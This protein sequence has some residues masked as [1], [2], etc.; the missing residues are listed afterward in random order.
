MAKILI[1]PTGTHRHSRTDSLKVRL[2][3]YA[4]KTEKAYKPN[5]V[6]V[7]VIPDGVT[8]EQLNDKVWVATLP[9]IWQLNPHLCLFVQVGADITKE[10]LLEWIGDVLTADVLATIDDSI[11]QPN[12]AHLIS[13]FMRDKCKQATSKVTRFDEHDKLALNEF[14]S[15]VAV[16]TVSGKAQIIEPQSI[17]VGAA[18][19]DRASSTDLS[20]YTLVGKENP[21]NA[22]GTIDTVEIWMDYAGTVEAATFEE[23]SANTLT[24][25]D[26]ESL[27]LLTAGSKQTISSLT[28]DIV[29]GDYI[30]CNG[31]GNIERDNSG[32]GYWWYVGDA[33]PCTSQAFTSSILRTISIYGTGTESGGGLSIPI[34]MHHYT[35]NI[36]S[37]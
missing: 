4:D 16:E 26:T 10:L 27:G 22:T 17:D 9:H 6:Y 5:F 36:G 24:S 28:I 1:N 14:L 13:P 29:T 23:V 34:A 33:I 2:D 3:I 37:N 8:E 32:T 12:S 30:G 7:P 31:S 19:I 21:A 35:K 18:A 25:R 20:I 15:G 11:I